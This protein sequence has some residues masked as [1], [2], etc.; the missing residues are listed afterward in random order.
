[1]TDPDFHLDTAGTAARP[2]AHRNRHPLAMLEK[3][4]R[5]DHEFV[6]DV[7]LRFDRLPDRVEAVVPVAVQRLSGLKPLEV[8]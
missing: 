8:L 5:L 7:E 2:L 4:L 3:P 1:M 6:E